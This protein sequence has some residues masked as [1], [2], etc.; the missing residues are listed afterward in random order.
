MKQLYQQYEIDDD[1]SRVDFAQVH[2]WLATTYWSPGISR[3]KV[4]RAARYS[5]LVVGVYHQQVQVAYLRV[6]SDQ[7]TF[8]WICDVFVDD[9]HRGQG[10]ARRMVR[11]ALEH[12]DHQGLRRW[13]LAT[14][15]AHGVYAKAGFEALPSP[16]RWMAYLPTGPTAV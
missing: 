14:K 1:L 16:E 6:V 4:E 13:L 7:T 5:S 12:P 10:L 15:D 3:E 9:A 8:A 11:F 2:G